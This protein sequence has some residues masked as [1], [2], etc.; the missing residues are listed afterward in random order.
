M[1]GIAWSASVGGMGTIIGT[2]P[3]GIAIGI[4]DSVLGKDPGYRAISFLDWMKFGIPYVLLFVPVIWLLL[5]RRFPAEKR[6]LEGGKD[7]LLAE[8]SKLGPLSSGERWTLTV[9]FSAVVLWV[10]NPF[11][12]SLF[13]PRFAERLSWVDEFTIGLFAGV[14]MFL[15]PVRLKDRRFVLEWEDTRLVD[16]GTLILFGGGIALS[17]AMFRSGLASWIAVNAVGLAGVPSTLL[18]VLVIVLLVDFLT[19]ITSNTAVTTMI[20]PVVISIGRAT[21]TDAVTLAVAAALA[22]SMAFMLPVATPPNALVFGTGQ[23]RLGDMMRTGL[24]LD[25]VGWL[26]TVFVLW[27]FG[28]F[29]FGIIHF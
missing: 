19:E 26:F 20:V 25:V 12:G 15:L 2:P 8:L 13:S 6:F 29:V 27:F 5:L 4:M 14:V 3:N 10:T 1:L 17:D 28:S 22:A 7:R 23:I 11:W 16:W 9:F 21:G 18:L 24:V